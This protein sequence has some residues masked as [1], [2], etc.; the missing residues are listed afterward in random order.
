MNDTDKHLRDL[1]VSVVEAA[2][3]ASTALVSYSSGT[4]QVN[5]DDSNERSSFTSVQV[6]GSPHRLRNIILILLLI[7][8]ILLIVWLVVVNN[9]P[10]GS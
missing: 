2:D 7:L 6:T 8:V 9:Y 4:P 10:E 1:W 3:K 5:E